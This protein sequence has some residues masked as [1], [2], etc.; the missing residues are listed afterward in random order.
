MN[1]K[2][3]SR[4]LFRAICCATFILVSTPS[5]S[6]IIHLKLPTGYLATAELLQ[7][8]AEMKPVLIQHGFLQTRDFFTVRR[9][10]E[11]LHEMG[12]TVLLPNLTLGIDNRRQSLACEAIHTHSMEQ[13]LAEIGFW[14][15]WLHRQSGKLVTLIGHSTGSLELFAYLAEASSPPV[16]QA[17]LISLLAF[18]QGPAAKENATELQRA[19]QQFAT[20]PEAI[21]SYR[22]AYCDTY[23]TTAK[24]YLSYMEWNRANTLNSLKKLP[25]KP[26]ILLGGEDR[27]LGDDWLPAM[28]QANAKVIPITG[29]DHFF[30]YEYEFELTDTVLELLEL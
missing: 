25:I 18:A 21:S 30:D 12:Y 19:R 15:D 9:L 13:D 6:E 17:I 28:R 14:V 29:A 8:E 22:L 23:N 26:T 11:A 5:V 4:H 1:N 7:G 10:G 16:N 20:D 2:T 27:R 24:N 3:L